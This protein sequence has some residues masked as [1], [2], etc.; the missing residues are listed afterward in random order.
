MVP[1]FLSPR[2]GIRHMVKWE[3]IENINSRLTSAHVLYVDHFIGNALG[4]LTQSQFSSIT[5]VI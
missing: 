3:I 4:S 1:R 2:S 5:A